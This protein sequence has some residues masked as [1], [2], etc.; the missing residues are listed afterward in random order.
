M[1]QS[2][3]LAIAVIFVKNSFFITFLQKAKILVWRIL[4]QIDERKKLFLNQ[5]KDIKS[6]IKN[7]RVVTISK[8]LKLA[9]NVVKDNPASN[10]KI[11]KSIFYVILWIG[12]KNQ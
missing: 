3:Y 12:L 1:Y 9:F 4:L 5:Q 8:F 10:R 11:L 2:K 6:T 7:K